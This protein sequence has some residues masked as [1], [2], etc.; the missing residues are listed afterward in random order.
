MD[1][2]TLLYLRWIINKYL[3]YS[4]G[5]SAQDYP[6]ASMGAGL[7]REWIHVLCMTE[8]LCCLPETVATLIGCTPIQHEELN[9]ISCERLYSFGLILLVHL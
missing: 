5:N 8:S 7:G 6:A 2:Y 1:M 4:T 9:K 3:L